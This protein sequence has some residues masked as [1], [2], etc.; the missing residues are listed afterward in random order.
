ML[1][2]DA[3]LFVASGTMGNLVAVLTHATRGDELIVGEDSHVML[4]E[5]GSIAALGGVI[6][7]TLPTDQFGRMDIA[8]VESAV[9]MDDV[10]LPRSRAIHVENSYGAK[11]GYPLPPEYFVAIAGVAR[12]HQLAVHMDGARL[13]NAATA[14]DLPAAE[15]ARHADSVTFCLSKGLCAPV[16][17][18]LCGSAEFV[19]GARRLRKALGGGMRQAGVLAAAG[20]VALEEMVGRLGDDHRL[21]R[22]MAEGLAEL[23]GI[24]VDLEK[25]K[26]N[27]VFFDLEEDVPH[28]AHD[29]A[30]HLRDEANIW[31][32]AEGDRNFRAVTHYWIGE[33]DVVLFLELLGRILRR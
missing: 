33:K 6:P 23:P 13:F 8:A 18:V 28:S 22:I 1:G 21:A 25:V 4:W 31:V 5:A 19:T 24:R 27:I 32:G 3:G 11:H 30:R 2:K 20:V 10:H 7:R 29:I 15:V 26:T 17:S 12:R 16:G 9:R 14:L